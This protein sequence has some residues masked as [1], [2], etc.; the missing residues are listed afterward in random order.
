MTYRKAYRGELPDGSATVFFQKEHDIAVV[1][2]ERVDRFLNSRM[3]GG[4]GEPTRGL[5]AY[6]AFFDWLESAADLDKESFAGICKEAYYSLRIGSIMHQWT[7]FLDIVQECPASLSHGPDYWTERLE[8]E[9]IHWR[10]H[11]LNMYKAGLRSD[12]ANWPSIL[13]KSRQLL[14][15]QAQVLQHFVDDLRSPC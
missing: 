7:Y 11:L 3:Q 14:D 4:N 13:N 9:L 5:Q 2:H 12:L 10:K 1:L 8:P 6:H 15:R